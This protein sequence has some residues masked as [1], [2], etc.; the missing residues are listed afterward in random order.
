[1]LV[2][3]SLPETDQARRELL[4]DGALMAFS[5]SPESKAFCDFAWDMIRDAFDPIDPADAQDVLSLERF[6]EIVA[7]LKPRFTH[8]MRAKELLAGLISSYGC[9]PTETYFDLPKL[10]V[11]THSGFL[12]AGVGYAYQPHRDVWYSCPPSQNNWWVPISQI[13]S[14]CSLA[15][16]PRYW[17]EMVDNSSGGFDAFEWNSNGRASAAKH[18]KSDPRNHP[19]LTSPVDLSQEL[20]V[21]GNPADVIIF[22]AAQLHA[23]VPNTSGRIRF[24][25]DF[26]TAHIDDLRAKRGAHIID[27]KSTG[28]TIHDFNNAADLSP[29]PT[30]VAKLYDTETE[31][32][33]VLVFTP[34][35]A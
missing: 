21:V 29:V 9:D 14:E 18:V 24:S 32:R 20:R 31:H 15:F 34:P 19:T 16:F 33:G 1:V 35:S 12:T 7:D 10:R 6:V 30:D 22:S 13:V 25:F 11:V 4:Y 28:S 2:Q 27:S 8:S 17:N 3:T 23:T 26:R 5:A